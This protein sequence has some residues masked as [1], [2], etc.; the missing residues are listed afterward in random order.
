VR[1]RLSRRRFVPG[2]AAGISRSP[3]PVYSRFP[4][5]GRPPRRRRRCNQSP[6]PPRAGRVGEV[7][8]LA[9]GERRRR[10]RGK[11]GWP[12]DYA[13]RRR[14]VERARGGLV[15]RRRRGEPLGHAVGLRASGGARATSSPPT[16]TGT[17]P[18][19]RRTAWIGRHPGRGERGASPDAVVPA[20]GRQRLG[21]RVRGPVLHRA[22]EQLLEQ[23]PRAL[24]P[25]LPLRRAG[26]PSP[27][28]R[29]GDRAGPAPVPVGAPS[30]ET[31]GPALPLWS[32][33]GSGRRSDAP[34][35]QAC[36]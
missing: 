26:G 19:T 25:R 2:A 10:L 32:W 31:R 33:A 8:R 35:G 30:A 9:P 12:D 27:T 18:A 23:A 24:R 29:A 3:Y 5:A 17:S 11:V 1:G 16:R 36:R 7:H 34:R 28:S 20:R 6:A 15:R 4:V 22:H 13:G 14:S 21:R